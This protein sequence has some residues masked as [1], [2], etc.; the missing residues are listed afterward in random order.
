MCVVHSEHIQFMVT[1]QCRLDF[2]VSR[3]P[4][5]VNLQQL[6][7]RSLEQLLQ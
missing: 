2:P 1:L 7:F 3:L 6:F 5:F 4:Q